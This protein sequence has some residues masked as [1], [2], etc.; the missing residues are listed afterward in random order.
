[1]SIEPLL[2]LCPQRRIDPTRSKQRPSRHIQSQAKGNHSAFSFRETR[3]I[4]VGQSREPKISDQYFEQL[5]CASPQSSRFRSNSGIEVIEKET[6]N[7]TEDAQLIRRIRRQMRFLQAKEGSE[8]HEPTIN[9]S[10]ISS[11]SYKRICCRITT[12]AVAESNIFGRRRKVS[13]RELAASHNQ[14]ASRRNVKM[15]TEERKTV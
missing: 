2:L 14:P 3:A 15:T 10:G 9:F 1:M 13:N 12:S 7:E 4:R 11:A 8:R 6:L 5:A